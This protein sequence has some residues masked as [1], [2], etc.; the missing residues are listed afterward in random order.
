MNKYAKM[1]VH[2][3]LRCPK[4]IKRSRVFRAAGNF[5][6]PGELILSAYNTAVENQEAKPW[7]AAYAASSYAE[8]LLWRK[9]GYQVQ[10][11]PAPLYAYAKTVDGDPDGDGTTLESALGALVKYGHFD[12]SICKIRSFGGVPFGNSTGLDDLKYA[13]HRYGVCVIGMDIDSSWF[14]PVK[15]V[16]RGGG[17]GQGGH[18]VCCT[19]YDPQGVIVL[20]SWGPEWGHDGFAYVPNAIF[21]KQFMYGAL[22]TRAL[23]G[24]Y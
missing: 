19:G 10:I 21:V 11:D 6:A 20:N 1:F 13:I 12:P 5:H 14:S 15:G 24:L 23:D 7:C 17:E 4:E 16:V 9:R 3:A 22:L 8:N 18:A 2:G